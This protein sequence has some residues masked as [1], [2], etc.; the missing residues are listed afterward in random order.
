MTNKYLTLIKKSPS[1]YRVQWQHG[2]D[3]GDFI[4]DVDGSFYYKP[5]LGGGTWSAHTM[6]VIAAELDGLNKSMDDEIA[7]FFKKSERAERR[8]RQ[9]K[10][11]VTF[12]KRKY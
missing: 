1:C 2:K 4:M 8:S 5:C 7:K 3:I 10:R 11:I 9:W 12:F 6:K